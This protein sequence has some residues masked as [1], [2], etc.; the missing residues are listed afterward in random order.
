MN[1]SNKSSEISGVCASDRA[2]SNL[3]VLSFLLVCVMPFALAWDSMGLLF[4]LV[5]ENDTFSQIPLIPLVSLFLVYQNR[6]AILAEVSFGGILAAAL[7]TPGMILLCVACL[8]LWHLSST[9]LVSLLVLAMVLFWVGAFALF[10][11]PRAFRAACFPLLFLIFM[12]PTPEPVLSKT[13]FLL[14]AGSSDMAEAFFRI[15]GVPYHRQGF[16]FEL[17]GVAIRV[18]AECSG[19]RSTLALLITAVLASY[20]F[21]KS[22]WRRLVLSS[23][24]IPI[25]IFKNGL[26]IA[27]LCLLSIYVNPG[28]LYGKLHR[29]GGI[30][31]F[32]IALLPMALLLRLLQKGENAPSAM[33]ACSGSG[34]NSNASFT[35]SE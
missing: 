13:I 15:A 19:I 20:I 5:L 1:F 25:A 18:A 12:V 28:F 27:T 14:Q 4:K 7:I 6:E 24:V 21:L 26:R 22:S 2:A 30:V 9:N 35:R 3:L 34:A 16:V 29:R 8:N 31:F 33:P 32:A 23:A 17:P 10:F 11:G